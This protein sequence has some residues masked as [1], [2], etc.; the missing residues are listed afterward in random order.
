[1]TSKPEI[2]AHPAAELFPMMGDARYAELLESI[3]ESGLELPILLCDGMI[4][5]G[6]NRYR[7]CIE[8]GVAPEFREFVGGD[9]YQRAWEL[10]GVRRDLD[11]GQRAAI[12][13]K[14]DMASDDWRKQQ[15]KKHRAA[16]EARRE[17]QKGVPKSEAMERHLSHDKRRS[18]EPDKTRHT[19]VTLA[20]RAGVGEATAGRAQALAGKDRGLL[21]KVASGEVKLTEAMRQ[22]KR[23]ELEKRSAPV[24]TGKYRVIYADPP[25]SYGNSGL[26][27]YGHAAS[28]YPQMSISDLCALP[29][30]GMADDNSVL[31]LWTTS[32]LLEDAFTV[33]RAW[34]FKYKTSFVWDKVRHNFGHYNSVRHEFLL[35]CTRGSCTPDVSTL[36]DSVVELERTKTH[37]EKP[38]RFREIIDTLYTGGSR[39]ELFARAAADGWEVWGLESDA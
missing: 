5:D 16:N 1:M 19:H 38:E 29:V 3:K 24:P 28:H 2:S 7:A 18:E 34:G 33:I 14:A 27:N 17:K 37:S 36:F 4:L 13:I 9:P 8:A 39:V 32:P 26:Q 31:F 12:R 6:R 20:K 10:N 30:K 35:V 21:D 11:A 15:E 22:L 23:K 25:W